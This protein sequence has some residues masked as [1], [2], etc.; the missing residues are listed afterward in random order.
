MF[1]R[2]VFGAVLLA[3]VMSAAAVTSYAQRNP[4]FLKPPAHVPDRQAVLLKI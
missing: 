2:V 4:G 1:R 3:M